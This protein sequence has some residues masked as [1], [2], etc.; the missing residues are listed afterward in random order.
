LKG[1]KDGG[2]PRRARKS[3]EGQSFRRLG[4]RNVKCAWMS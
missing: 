4:P 3:T 1:L 2:I